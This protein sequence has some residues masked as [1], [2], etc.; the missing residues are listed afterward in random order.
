MAMPSPS[1][2]S[3]GS[4][5]PLFLIPDLAKLVYEYIATCEFCRKKIGKLRIDGH[6]YCD[7]WCSHHGIKIKFKHISVISW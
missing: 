7:T 2:V 3:K 5:D 6:F 4:L 1:G